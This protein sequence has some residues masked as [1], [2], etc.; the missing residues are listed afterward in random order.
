LPLF[1]RAGSQIRTSLC[2]RQYRKQ[3]QIERHEVGST[4]QVTAGNTVWSL[5][6]F[7]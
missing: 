2:N 4:A 3:L 7:R 5:V 6:N 1:E